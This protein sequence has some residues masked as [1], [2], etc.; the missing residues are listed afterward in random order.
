MSG[1]RLSPEEFDL[2]RNLVRKECGIAVGDEKA[3]L[4]ETRLTSLVKEV[5]C[6]SFRTFYEF[7]S[8]ATNR[9]I[10]DRMIDAMTTNETLWFRDD[11]PWEILR[12]QLIPEFFEMLKSGSRRTIRIWSAAS[13]TGQEPYS[14]AMSI[15]QAIDDLKDPSIKDE[16][17]EIFGTDLSPSALFVANSGRYDPM[18]ISRGLDPASK[19]KFFDQVGGVHSVGERVRSRVTFKRYNLMDSFAEFGRFDLVLCRNV[20]IYFAPELKRDIVERIA[21]TLHDDGCFIVGASESL[22]GCLHRYTMQMCEGQIYYRRKPGG[23]A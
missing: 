18:S 22:Q 3:Y 9:E 12:T 1:L 11:G 4:V 6:D 23:E 21:N 10:R 15:L 17:F 20:L 5:G 14:V 8:R 7:V 2:I 16:Q 13:S 19:E